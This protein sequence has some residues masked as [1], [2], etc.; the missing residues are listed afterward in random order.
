M[1]EQSMTSWLLNLKKSKEKLSTK[2]EDKS[3]DASSNERLTLF[4]SR[5]KASKE[6]L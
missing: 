1:Y 2:F 5:L 6:Q 3:K 4:K